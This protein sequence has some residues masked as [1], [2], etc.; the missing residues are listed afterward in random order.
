METDKLLVGCFVLDK[1]TNQPHRIKARDLFLLEEGI[2]SSDNF[3]PIPLSINILAKNGFARSGE[4][5]A[6]HCDEDSD[7][8]LEITWEEDEN[9]AF[10]TINTDEYRILALRT[11]DEL[12]IA[13]KLCG[14]DKIIN[15]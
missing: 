9:C 11:V 12:Q 4:V 2:I 13:L 3:E 5:W 8:M 7:Y 6:A 10:W 1:T 14:I 15:L